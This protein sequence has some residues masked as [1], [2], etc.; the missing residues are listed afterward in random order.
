[1]DYLKSFLTDLTQS[2][3]YYAETT[4]KVGEIYIVE[5]TAPDC[6]IELFGDMYHVN[7]RCDIPAIIIAQLMYDMTILDPDII[8]NEGFMIHHE[9]GLIYGDEARG[10]FY[11]TVYSALEI[12]R[13][14]EENELNTVLYTVQDPIYAYG[15]KYAKRNKNKRLWDIDL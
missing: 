1:M 3:R 14:K 12:V 2:E 11:A 10:L 7:F 9:R 4:D 5:D 15:H 6:L 8:V 13:I